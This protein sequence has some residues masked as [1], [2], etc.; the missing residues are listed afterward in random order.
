M[1]P[2]PDHGLPVLDPT[3]VVLGPAI[4]DPDLV[5]LALRRPVSPSTP[6]SA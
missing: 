1:E 5:T 4:T 6:L 3:A 2:A